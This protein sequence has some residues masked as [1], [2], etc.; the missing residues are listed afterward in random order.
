M[1]EYDREEELKQKF[2]QAY[3][4]WSASVKDPNCFKG[5]RRDR[6]YFFRTDGAEGTTNHGWVLI[7]E[8]SKS[9]E[10]R[11][12]KEYTKIRDEYLKY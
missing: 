9:V 8:E 2:C 12:W 3:K 7:P 1:S 5:E 6:A 10:Y 11:L 4:H